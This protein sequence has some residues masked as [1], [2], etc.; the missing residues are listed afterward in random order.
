M[1]ESGRRILPIGGGRLLRVIFTLALFTII[2]GSPLCAL[3]VDAFVS[4]FEV[5]TGESVVIT[6]TVHTADPSSVNFTSSNVPESFVLSSSRKERSQIQGSGISSAQRTPVTIITREW[7]PSVA[8]NFTVGPFVF[9]IENDSVTLPSVSLMVRPSEVA[10]MTGLRWNI[11]GTDAKSGSPIEISLEGFFN[12]TIVN[13]DCSAPENAILEAVVPLDDSQNISSS[14]SPWRVLSRY[15]WTPISLGGQ[16]LPLAIVEYTDASGTTHSLASERRSLQVMQEAEPKKS[17][18]VL[19]SV[20]KAFSASP[21][22]EEEK[23]MHTEVASPVIP[24]ELRA[25]LSTVPWKKGNYALF[26]RTYRQAEYTH[27][28]PGRFRSARISIEKRLDLGDTLRVPLAAWKTWSVIGAV[29]LALLSLFLYLSG[30]KGSWQHLASNLSLFASIILVIFAVIIYTQDLKP[31][32]VVTGGFLLHVPEQ[33]STIIEN[34]QEGSTARILRTS[35]DWLYVETD[36]MLK[37][38]ITTGQ[39]LQYTVME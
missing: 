37:G 30:R 15:M 2:L 16:D 26:L 1:E 7:I 17:V 39:L 36:S 20:G 9:S 29:M 31:A 33:N 34:L 28:F 13:I 12:G 24:S 38:W 22:R 19:K 27:V 5:V 21:I 35:G 11:S 3:E 6:F 25:T 14:G 4:S 10:E 32:G 8:G 18:A 23:P